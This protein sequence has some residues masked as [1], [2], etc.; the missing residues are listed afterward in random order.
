[1]YLKS[2]W[3]GLGYGGGRFT[4]HSTDVT[5]RG[6]DGGISF[7]ASGGGYWV[8][9]EPEFRATYFGLVDTSDLAA[10]S[11]THNTWEAENITNQIPEGSKLIFDPGFTFKSYGGFVFGQDDY[12]TVHVEGYGAILTRGN[13][14]QDSIKSNSSSWVRV[15]H[16]ER[17][18][19]FMY[20]AAYDGTDRMI[21]SSKITRIGGDTLFVAMG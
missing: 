21:T 12:K 10:I 5:G 17:W 18:D 8:R 9:T 15:A 11:K 14:I 7:A 1:M 3:S 2:Y 16:P 20:V 13:Q 4:W 6:D 19:T